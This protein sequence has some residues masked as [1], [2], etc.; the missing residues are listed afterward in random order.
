MRLAFGSGPVFWPSSGFEIR[1]LSKLQDDFY[2]IPP[3]PPM[4]PGIDGAPE[5]SDGLLAIIA[6]VV[7]NN[8]AT[9]AAFNSA[10]FVTLVGSITPA[11]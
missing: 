9:E 10:V 8:P 6:S 2:I 3:M 1:K 4:P 11:L 5:S 7:N